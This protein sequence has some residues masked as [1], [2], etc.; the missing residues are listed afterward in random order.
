[1][2]RRIQR[3]VVKIGGARGNAFGSL[4]EEIKERMERGEQWILAHGASSMMEDLS[5]PPEWNPSTSQAPEASEA[6]L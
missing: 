2:N 1:M 5:G 6:V 3:G 4:P